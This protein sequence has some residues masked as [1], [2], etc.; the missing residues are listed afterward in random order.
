MKAACG[1]MS[2]RDALRWGIRALSRKDGDTPRLDAEVLLA[3]ILECP[4]SVV[5]SRWDDLLSSPQEERYR[6]LIARRANHEPVAYLVGERAFFDLDLSVDPRVLIPRPE[7]EHLVEAALVWAHDQPVDGL[8]IVDVGTGSGAL[9]LAVA[10]HL[11]SA[12]VWA[13]DVSHDAL[14]V[15]SANARRYG[16]EER[17]MLVCGDLLVS[18]EGTFDLVLAN[19]PYIPREDVACL[20]PDVVRYEPRVALDGGNGGLELVERLLG[21]LASRLARPG[22]ALLEIDEGQAD[23]VIAWARR[24]LPDA[25]LGVIKDYAGLER[26]VQLQRD[27]V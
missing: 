10:R 13:T 12:S 4:R 14:M 18:L 17:I 11:P 3:C 22:L 26:V 6:G 16:L 27:A 1:E 9:A 15:A 20:M 19:L 2:V 25:K 5:L 7:S 8:R 21:Q 24:S 23:T